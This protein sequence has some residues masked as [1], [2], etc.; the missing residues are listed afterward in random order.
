M[1]AG[2]IV[3]LQI[4]LTPP[5]EEI[6]EAVMSI[7]FLPAVPPEMPPPIIVIVQTGFPIPLSG[8]YLSS[9]GQAQRFDAGTRATANL[10]GTRTR[11]SYVRP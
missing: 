1:H 5:Y 8:V 7:G 3:I 2:K 10:D 9:E 4:V 6:W 11:W